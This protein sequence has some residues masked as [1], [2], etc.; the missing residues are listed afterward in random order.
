MIFGV[1]LPNLFM[2][3]VF[4]FIMS[5]PVRVLFIGED[6]RLYQQIKS[7][8]ARFAGK[9]E[10][11]CASSPAELEDLLACQPLDAAITDLAPFGW[12]DFAVIGFVHNKKPALPML[13]FSADAEKSA[14]AILQGAVYSLP[15]TPENLTRLPALLCDLIVSC[16]KRET[17]RAQVEAALLESEKQYHDL[18]ESMPVGLYRTTMDGNILDVNPALVEML[19]YSSREELLQHN[20]SEFFLHP[21]D[22]SHQNLLLEQEE[23]PHPFEVEMRCKNGDVIWVRD[24]SRA[25]RDAN[26]KITFYEGSLDDITESKQTEAKIRAAQT[27]LE[28]LLSA[29]PTVLFTCDTQPPFHPTFLSENIVDLTGYPPEVFMSDPDFW[30]NHIHPEDI[31]T[32]QTLLSNLKQ[33]GRLAHE[34]RFIHRDGSVRWLHDEWRL[35]CDAS[36]NPIEVI[37]SS[38]DVTERRQTEET[39]ARR[40]ATLES[41]SFAAELFLKESDLEQNIHRVLEH[42]GKATSVSRIYILQND[43]SEDGEIF[44]SS[45]YEWLRPGQSPPLNAHYLNEYSFHASGTSWMQASLEEGK[46]IFGNSED[47]PQTGINGF[48]PTE[49]KSLALV[50]IFVEGKWWGALGFEEYTEKRTWAAAERDALKVA[51]AIFAAAFWRKNAEEALR[52]SERKFRSVFE[53]AG[54]GIAIIDLEGNFIQVNPNLQKMLGYSEDELCQLSLAGVTHPDDLSDELVQLGKARKP[55]EET[56]YQTEKR[57]IRKDGRI[58][59]GNLSASIILDSDGNSIFGLGLVEDITER[60]T[61]EQVLRDTRDQLA[62]RI[63]DLEKRANELTILSSLSNMLQLCSQTSEAFGWIAQFCAQLFPTLSGGLFIVDKETNSLEIQTSWGNPAVFEGTLDRHDCWALRRGRIHKVE[64]LSSD[65]V[66]RHVAEPIPPSYLCAPIIIKS[67]LVGLFYLQSNPNFPHLTEADQQLAVAVAEQIGLSL[68]NIKLNLELQEL[69][70]HDSLTGLYNRRYMMESLNRELTRASRR[71][72]PVSLIHL[73]FDCLHDLNTRLGHD[74]VDEMLGNLGQLIRSSVRSEDIACRFGGDEFLLILSEM[75][76]DTARQRAGELMERIAAL[77]LFDANGN[78]QP[79]TAAI[80]IACY[81]QHGKTSTEI[82]KAIHKT[83]DKAKIQGG[84]CV[85]IADAM[86]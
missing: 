62:L 37:G 46:L 51:A 73:D 21:E 11:V 64:D 6:T 78:P 75:D 70:I 65:L 52:E 25:V 15:Q 53:W 26:G 57:Y 68:A 14:Q 12:A 63:N 16:E 23:I 74:A 39:L 66:C 79:I 1:V 35:V 29:S 38:T 20:A 42:L 34:Y 71:G 4:L 18:F 67:Q 76:V 2:W 44:T 48:V 61:A 69:A 55:G 60:K 85:V 30:S 8:L 9:V 49:V 54:V 43:L 56:F 19:G 82:M 77:N 3:K 27:R 28:Y 40:E 72:K 86:E 31:Q 22:R 32:V 45:K 33:T 81:P 84:N 58:V 83:L 36:N 7:E 13:V 17:P 10:L 41:V 59:W 24:I 5:K 47:F 50:P 80:S